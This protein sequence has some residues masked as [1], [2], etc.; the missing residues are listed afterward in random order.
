V[1]QGLLRA[2]LFLNDTAQLAE[3][4]IA[5]AIVIASAF[6]IS[7]HSLLFATHTPCPAPG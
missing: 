6:V 3:L 7:S 2:K 5:I 4:A 1:L